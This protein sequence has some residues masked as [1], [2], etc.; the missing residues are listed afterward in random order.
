MS[1]YI[2]NV[3]VDFRVNYVILHFEET[4]YS[5]QKCVLFPS[6][7]CERH[8]MYVICSHHDIYIYNT[9]KDGVEHHIGGNTLF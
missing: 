5:L 9:T 7:F 6:V 4:N 1:V 8:L 2:K 3:N